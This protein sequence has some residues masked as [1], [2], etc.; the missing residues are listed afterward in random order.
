M[1]A[2]IAERDPPYRGCAVFH[3]VVALS[4]SF[5]RERNGLRSLGGIRIFVCALAFTICATCKV[6]LAIVSTGGVFRC[7]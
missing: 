4:L 5:N 6:A 1:V 7:S 2:G 3:P